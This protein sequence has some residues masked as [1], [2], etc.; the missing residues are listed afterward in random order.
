[1]EKWGT[2][3]NFTNVTC[4]NEVCKDQDVYGH[5]DFIGNGISPIKVAVEYR[6]LSH[7]SAL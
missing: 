6:L 7:E 1:M 3:S 5:R 2:K 4:K